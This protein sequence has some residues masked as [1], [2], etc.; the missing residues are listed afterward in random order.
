MIGRLLF[1]LGCP[2]HSKDFN[3]VILYCTM[4]CLQLFL[5]TQVNQQLHSGTDQWKTWSFQTP[6]PPTRISIRGKTLPHTCTFTKNNAPTTT[7]HPKIIPQPSP[8]TQNNASPT[9]HLPKIMHHPHPPMQN[10]AP[11]TPT[12]PYLPTLMP[13]T[14]PRTPSHPNKCLTNP[15]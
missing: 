8:L 15:K 13:H 7:T 10:N 4:H 2:S 12:H 14:P 3:G 5:K 9:P 11:L 1:V 6:S